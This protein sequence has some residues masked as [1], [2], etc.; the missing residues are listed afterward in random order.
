MTSVTADTNIYISGLQFKGPN[1]RRFLDLAAE[2]A[3][4]LDVS[5]HIIHEMLLVLREK[6]AWSME[7]LREAEEEI[8]AYTHH[9]TPTHTVSVITADPSDNRILECAEAA[10]SDF[11]VSGDTR[12]VLPL[13]SHT[14]IP[15]VTVADFLRWLDRTVTT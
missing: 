5:D 13:G 10:S 15:I 1:P 3:F 14:G 6:F 2:G 4:R 8:R 9:V 11:I 7:L 12:H